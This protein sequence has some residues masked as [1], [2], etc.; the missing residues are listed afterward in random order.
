MVCKS[1]SPALWEPRDGYSHPPRSPGAPDDLVVEEQTDYGGPF[2]H[3]NNN[4]TLAHDKHCL[5]HYASHSSYHSPGSMLDAASIAL[6][7]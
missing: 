7:N 4:K 2:P 3:N 5:P 1:N 6:P